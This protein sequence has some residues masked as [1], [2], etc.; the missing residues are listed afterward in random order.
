M[1]KVYNYE[2]LP[3]DL[4]AFALLVDGGNIGSI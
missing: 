4:D 2:D 1:S 3:V